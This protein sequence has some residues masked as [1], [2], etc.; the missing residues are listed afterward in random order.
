LRIPIF[1]GRQ[2]TR[3]DAFFYEGGG[4]IV[5][6]EVEPS[7][8]QRDNVLLKEE[9]AKFLKEVAETLET[10]ELAMD[11]LFEKTHRRNV[12]AMDV[13]GARPSE[14]SVATDVE[15]PT[16][17]AASPEGAAADAPPAD[18]AAAPPDGASGAAVA[19]VQKHVAE[20][21]PIVERAVL[22]VLKMLAQNRISDAARAAAL[23]ALRPFI[24]KETATVADFV[25]LME[26]IADPGD[27]VALTQSHATPAP[28][29]RAMDPTATGAGEPSV[30]EP[31]RIPTWSEVASQALAGAY[32]ARDLNQSLQHRPRAKATAAPAP[33]R[34]ARR[35]AQ[36]Q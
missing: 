28:T 32:K 35:G 13:D 30:P 31:Q 18:G 17:A 3:A 26:G 24:P 9:C 23:T 14:E 33:K 27:L 25:I 1:T 20:A 2:L 5:R 19:A 15:R 22:R 6:F 7:R 29:T 36:R 12:G 21:M 10:N 8:P 34:R 4:A 11:E 16:G